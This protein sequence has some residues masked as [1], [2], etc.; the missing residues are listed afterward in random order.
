ME[1]Q[2]YTIDVPAERID[3]LKERLAI[4]SFPDELDEA[5]W[6]YGAPLKDIKRLADYWQN[7]YDWKA[8]EAKINELPNYQ[9]KVPVRGFGEL[10][11][12]F[13]HQKSSIGNA[14]PLLFVH[15]CMSPNTPFLLHSFA[16]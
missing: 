1:P 12:H 4:S 11:V 16:P 2:T 6:D 15:G 9:T 8:Q 13:V 10:D 5:Q 3:Q 7:K 14:I